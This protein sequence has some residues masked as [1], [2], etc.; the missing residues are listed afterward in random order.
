ML[1]YFFFWYIF[2]IFL[3]FRFFCIISST[4][5]IIFYKMSP[6][7]NKNF[8][9]SHYIIIPSR[10]LSRTRED[11]FEFFKDFISNWWLLGDERSNNLCNIWPFSLQK[12]HTTSRQ[13]CSSNSSEVLNID[14]LFMNTNKQ[15]HLRFCKI[16]AW[17]VRHKHEQHKHKHKGRNS[18]KLQAFR[19]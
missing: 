18:A 2:E 10:K 1:L 5:R 15:Y 3:F 8:T 7:E 9:V 14:R 6:N 4:P 16:L 13:N 19:G 12:I 11:S 17:I